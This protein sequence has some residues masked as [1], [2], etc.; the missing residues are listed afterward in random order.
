MYDFKILTY[1]ACTKNVTLH[2][3]LIFYVFH[4]LSTQKQKSIIESS[5]KAAHGQ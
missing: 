2:D 5:N 4:F 3:S 1:M